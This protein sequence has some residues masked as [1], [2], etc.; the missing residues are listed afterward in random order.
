MM[1]RKKKTPRGIRLNNPCNIRHGQGRFIGE[2]EHS[3]DNEFRQFKTMFYGIRAAL[4]LLIKTY[5]YLHRL[6]TMRGIIKRWAP[7]NENNT[8]AYI[9]AMCKE[10]G[11]KPDE[12]IE[13]SE[14]F[15][16]RFLDAMIYIENGVR[17]ERWVIEAVVKTYYHQFKY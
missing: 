7:S 2:M 17:V 12:Y 16:I 10:V 4:H 5:Y 6:R 9:N 13:M 8:Q 1:E 11:L 14:D 3:K 15:W